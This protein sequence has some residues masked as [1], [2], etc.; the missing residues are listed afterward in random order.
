VKVHR[1]LKDSFEKLLQGILQAV[2]QGPVV[3][4]PDLWNDQFF[5]DGTLTPSGARTL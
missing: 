5:L 4:G 3:Q 2:V 1:N